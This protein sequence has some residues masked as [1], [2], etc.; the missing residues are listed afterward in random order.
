MLYCG[1]HQSQLLSIINDQITKL[2]QRPQKWPKAHLSLLINQPKKAPDGKQALSEPEKSPNNG[3]DLEAWCSSCV[4]LECTVKPKLHLDF[5]DSADAFRLDPA[6]SKNFF[7]L[8]S[9]C[10]SP[11]SMLCF[12]LPLRFAQRVP[13]SSNVNIDEVLVV[14]RRIF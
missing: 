7:L 5:D 10:S 14:V 2:S 12:L 1:S 6:S 3:W 4:G 9:C 11:T 8:H 13:G